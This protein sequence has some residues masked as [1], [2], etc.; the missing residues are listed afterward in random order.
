M[1]RVLIVDPQPASA[2]LL[3]ELL[4][5]IGRCQIWTARRPRRAMTVAQ[6]IEPHV[7]FVEHGGE[8]RRRRL[9]PR[10]AP[11]RYVPPQAAVIMISAQATA[12]AIIAA[13]DA[14]VHEFLRKPFTIK[15]LLRRLEAVARRP[16]DW[17][18]GIELRRPRPPPVQLRRLRRA[19]E[20]PRRPRQRRPTRRASCRRCE[21]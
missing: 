20:A 5:D 17:I 14:G 16:R 3:S 8:P 9:H 1:Q 2:K 6:G 13:R 7:I 12:A 10:P 21:S 15:D 4:R 11:Q 19:A 18:E